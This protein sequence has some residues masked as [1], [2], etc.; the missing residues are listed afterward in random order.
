M[1]FCPFEPR[2]VQFLGIEEVRGYHLKCY[3]IEYG[4]VPFRPEEFE[5]GMILAAC[6]VPKPTVTDGRPGVGFVIQHQGRTGHYLILC[7]WDNENELPPRVFVRTDDE[8]RPA[9]ESESFCVWDLEVMWR[10]REAYVRT[11]LGGKA[12]SEYLNVIGD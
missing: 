10:E 7:W 9:R 11:V 1:P 8:W 2:P 5:G 12:V 4:E 6:A 3:S